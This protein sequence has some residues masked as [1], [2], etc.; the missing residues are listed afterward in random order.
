[1]THAPV[2]VFMRLAPHF[3][4]AFL[5]ATV[6]C[7]GTSAAADME[8]GRILYEALCN[9]C[10]AESVHGRQ[11]RASTDLEALRGR[12]RQWS[13]NLGLKWTSDEV[14]DVAA[15]LNARYYRFACPPADCMVTGSRD[16]G[17]RH[18]Y[19]GRPVPLKVP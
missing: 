18:L 3:R 4:I 14:N 7:A 16:E 10:H 17:D 1:M 12:V 8:R 2:G 19:V 11:K 9:G 5:A 13:V 15:H 6:V